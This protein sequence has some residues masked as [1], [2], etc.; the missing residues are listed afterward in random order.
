MILGSKLA[1]K[2][3]PKGVPKTTPTIKYVT[4]FQL[5]LFQILGIIKK[6]A[7]ISSSKI[8]GTIS[9]G[10]IMNDNKDTLDAEKPKPLKPLTNDA[11]KITLA[12]KINSTKS[13]SIICK[14]STSL[15]YSHWIQFYIKPIKTYI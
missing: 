10:G 12:R 6:L 3:T 5:I 7:T 4:N 8:M 13:N 1:N 9:F 11:S 15:Q 14:Y 2:L